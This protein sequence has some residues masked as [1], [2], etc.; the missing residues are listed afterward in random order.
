ME[1]IVQGED[2]IESR[3]TTTVTA[4]YLCMAITGIADVLGDTLYAGNFVH[5]YVILES[6]GLILLAVS[7]LAYWNRQA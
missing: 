2:H 7:L 4:G 6:V 5:G 3:S 1:G